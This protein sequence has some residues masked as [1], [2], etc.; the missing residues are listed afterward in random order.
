MVHS[1]TQSTFRSSGIPSWGKWKLVGELGSALHLGCKQKYLDLKFHVEC[2]GVCLL[3]HG[4]QTFCNQSIARDIPKS[5]RKRSNGCN[6][7]QERIPRTQMSHTPYLLRVALGRRNWNLHRLHLS[8][9]LWASKAD[10]CCPQQMDDMET[11]TASCSGYMPN[12]QSLPEK[13]CC[14]FLGSLEKRIHKAE[15]NLLDWPKWKTEA[16]DG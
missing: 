2:G 10:T 6:M 12:P 11:H 9:G 13:R 3:S 14:T 15:W 4:A 16:K 5:K 8:D 7:S 1:S